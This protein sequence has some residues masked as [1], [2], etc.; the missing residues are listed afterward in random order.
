MQESTDDRGPLE[1]ELLLMV[2]SHLIR[3]LGTKVRSS[4]QTV[5]VH[6]LL[7]I[8]KTSF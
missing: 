1:V 3:E 7:L 4:T 2:V 6:V 8:N 5:V